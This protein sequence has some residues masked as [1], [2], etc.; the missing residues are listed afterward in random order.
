LSDVIEHAPVL[1]RPGSCLLR[2]SGNV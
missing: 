1:L 2:A